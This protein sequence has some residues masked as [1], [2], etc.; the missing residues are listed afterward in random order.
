MKDFDKLTEFEKQEEI[1]KIEDKV[2]DNDR[3]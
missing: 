2:V 1:R 3:H